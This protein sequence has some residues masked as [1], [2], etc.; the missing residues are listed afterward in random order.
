MSEAPQMSQNA[1]GAGGAAAS[2]EGREYRVELDMY[3]GPLELLLYLIRRDE[4]DIKNIPISRITEQYLQHVDVIRRIDINLAGEFLVMAATLLEIK[5]RMLIPRQAPV[6]G[7]NGEGGGSSTVE[8]LADPRYELVKQ[9]LAYKEFKDAA[10]DLKRRAQSE[11]SRFPR[12]VTRPTG[13]TPLDIEDL[14]LFRLIDAFNG[15][16]ASVGHS[17][18]GHEVV[19]D[20]TPI[21]LHQADILDRL[22]R[23]TR[24]DGNARGLTL[25]E[26]FIGRTS[27][28][29]MIGL[30]LAT[31]ELIRQK[32][33]AVDTDNSGGAGEILLRLREDAGEQRLFEE[34]T[35]GA[36]SAGA[37]AKGGPISE[38]PAPVGAG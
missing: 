28:S 24:E 29:E 7:E 6:P 31:L 2:G 30:F 38:G 5:S 36:D 12:A 33:V 23:Q 20:D 19:Y 4:V 3:S 13:R 22:I 34:E 14:D 25:Q 1:A 37:E 16:M 35:G 21:S 18:F 26:L 9:L 17:A 10:G 32:K 15:I 27:K 8:D 11:A